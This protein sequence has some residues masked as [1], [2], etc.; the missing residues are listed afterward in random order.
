MLNFDILIA[1][2][3]LSQGFRVVF[4]ANTFEI[5]KFKVVQAVSYDSSLVNHFN[6]NNDLSKFERERLTKILGKY[7]STR[8]TTGL[9]SIRLSDPHKTVQ[10]RSYRLGEEEKANVRK[11]I[12]ELLSARAVLPLLVRKCWSKRRTEQIAYVLIKGN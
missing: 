4:E 8:V 5:H 12:D 10:R 11:M 3:I 9:L 2:E 1:R 7:S 6:F